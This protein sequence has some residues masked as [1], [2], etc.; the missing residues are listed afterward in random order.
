MPAGLS[1]YV[2]TT[3]DRWF[4]NYYHGQ[5]ALGLYAVGAKFAMLVAMVVTTFRQAWWPVAMD[6]M[7]SEDGP[8]LYRTIARLYMG[9]GSAGIVFLTA[10]SPSLV[11]WFTASAFHAAYPIVGILAWHSIFYGFYLIV[12][13]GIW[14]T[15]KTLWAPFLMGTA[16]FLNIGLDACLVPK[17]GNIGA[18]IATSIS[19]LIWNILTIVVSEKLWKLGYSFSILALQVSIGGVICYVILRMYD[20]GYSLFYVVLV[21]TFAIVPL[22]LLSLTRDHLGKAYQIVMREI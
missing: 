10:V 1:M 19:F 9:L 18:A 4:L 21:S 17:Y 16:A 22:L 7:Y 6:A 14:K 2:L 15:E 5:D 8:A 13:A 11:R 20:Q 3:A 12:A